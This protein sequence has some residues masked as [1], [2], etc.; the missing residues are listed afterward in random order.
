[1]HVIAAFAAAEASPA[2]LEECFLLEQAAAVVDHPGEPAPSRE[3]TLARL[4]RTP[5]PG[6][7]RLCWLAREPRDAD[8]V[9]T[10]QLTGIANLML[11]G[12]Q[13]FDLAGFDLTVHP[14]HRRRG[15]AAALLREVVSAAAARQ[16]LLVEGI[17]DGSAGQAWV[18][19]QG[20]GVAQR[21]LQLTIDLSTVDRT[22]WRVPGSPGY[23]LAHWTGSTPAELL[24]SY[25]A[26]RNAIAEAPRG[27][28]TFTEPAWTPERVRDEEDTARARACELRVVAAV[29]EES[30]EV[31]GLTYLE[32]YRHQP[33]LAI[34]QDT[35][36]LARH[37]GHGLGAWM[38]A[39]NLIRLTADHPL[40]TRVRTSNAADNTHMLR[41]NRQVGFAD[42]VATEIREAKVAHLASRL[43]ATQA[44]PS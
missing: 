42:E 8:G 28:M 16:T 4:T 19:A 38:K 14:E 37:R 11:E 17:T 34:Q 32:V 1:M 27:D 26:A 35:A 5:A 15:V 40:V 7:R 12:E 10:G 18:A 29:H 2:E 20:F 22:R 13:A 6:R 36:V 44:D 31:A 43:V 25:A 21:T 24:D 9:T 30:A 23:Q 39:A 41:V 33:A 3:S